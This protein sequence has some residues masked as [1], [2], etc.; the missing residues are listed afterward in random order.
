MA[1][2]AARWLPHRVVAAAAR[3]TA[4][5]PCVCVAWRRASTEALVVGVD[6]AGRGAVLGPLVLGCV[7]L[8][9][10]TEALL[11]EE[12]VRDSKLLS[13]KERTRLAVFIR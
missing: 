2:N 10:R 5:P 4:R 12:G 7:L 11:Q 6:E 8:T 1:M 13:P 3:L 9:R